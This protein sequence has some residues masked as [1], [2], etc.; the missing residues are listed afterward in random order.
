MENKAIFI[1][2]VKWSNYLF[3]AFVDNKEECKHVAYSKNGG[4][5]QKACF[6]CAIDLPQS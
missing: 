2:E 1:F 4:Q 6:E 3:A 5:G